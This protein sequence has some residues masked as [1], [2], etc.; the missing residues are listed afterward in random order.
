MYPE[1]RPYATTVP[2]SGY[3]A[4]PL[5]PQPPTDALA[6]LRSHVGYDDLRRSAHG[7]SDDDG[8]VA[9]APS[10][11]RTPA[12]R[13]YASPTTATAGTAAT[14][15]L[16]PSTQ[17]TPEEALRA[18]ELQPPIEHDEHTYHSCQQAALNAE[19]REK[20][21]TNSAAWSARIA[22][23]QE[24]L[25]SLPM[26][27]A[28]FGTREVDSVQKY[29]N[30]Y[31]CTDGVTV[32]EAELF[33]QG[34][35]RTPMREVEAITQL[36]PAPSDAMRRTLDDMLRSPY[37]L[38]PLQ[39]C[40][41]KLSALDKLSE[42]GWSGEGPGHPPRASPTTTP[43]TTNTTTSASGQLVNTAE[44]TTG[45]EMVL[46]PSQ[47]AVAL[48]E[49][50]HFNPGDYAEREL[51]KSEEA[52]RALQQRVH[53]AKEQKE[54]AIDANDPITA[55]RNLHAQ[56]DFS[57][58]MLLLYKARMVQVGMHADDVQDFRREVVSLI[59]DARRAVDATR[60]YA[61][62]ALPSVHH[63]I[64]VTAHAIEATE[65]T[66]RDARAA[67]Q[68]VVTQ[69]REQLGTM[70]SESR[71]LW[72]E[73]LALLERIAAKAQER[74][75]YVQQC[76]SRRE[77]RAKVAAQAEAQLK[78]R[79]AHREKLRQ[80]EEVLTRWE[81]LGNV[82]A[83]YVEACVPKL[84]MHLSAVEDA[85]EDLSQREAE[86]YV[87][88]FEQFVYAAEEARAKRRTQADRMRLLQRSVQLNQERAEDTLDPDATSHAQRLAYATRELEEVQLYL[89]YIDDMEGER[90]AEVDPVL[91]RVLVRHAQ[92]QAAPSVDGGTDGGVVAADMSAESQTT[93]ALQERESAPQT[94]AAKGQ[95]VKAAATSA[96]ASAVMAAAPPS[97]AAAATNNS[98][99]SSDRTSLTPPSADNAVVASTGPATMAHPLV[100]ARRIGLTHEENYLQKQEQLTARELQELEGKLTGLRHSREELCA[101]ETKYQNAG[102]IRA[103]LGLE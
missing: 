57:N 33:P 34:T 96:P 65:N 41:A 87:S 78:A 13:T 85:N 66:L 36:P 74:N 69:L 21:E 18:A 14:Q 82:Y 52:L 47:A 55:L 75:R 39:G 23:L 6:M 103:L 70:D 26:E 68:V 93:P 2:H 30:A 38:A 31:R 40:V 45:A 25:A 10:A 60:L 73:V 80:C 50:L 86:G 24:T 12:G 49:R 100:A 42:L 7:S 4:K 99:S 35:L 27:S 17:R 71:A 64:S 76:M 72:Q 95:E 84:L 97:A 91:Q 8:G 19:L 9:A 94:N 89:K 62:Q 28:L 98:N 63:D 58:D 43:N 20:V 61:R 1:R 51:K 53:A 29:L 90:R 77:Q 46:S 48:H 3:R 83:K 11:V 67:E 102:A 79:N 101:I 5:V 22:V 59:D 32:P 81:E 44:G 15:R 37:L 16:L 56:V 54:N 88:A 92:A